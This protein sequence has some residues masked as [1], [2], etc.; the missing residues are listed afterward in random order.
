MLLLILTSG[1]YDLYWKNKTVLIGVSVSEVLEWKIQMN[2]TEDHLIHQ[3][4]FL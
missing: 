4:K 2:I 1:L 3:I